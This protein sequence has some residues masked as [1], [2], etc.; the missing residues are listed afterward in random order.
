MF[1]SPNNW[2]H[3]WDKKR[4]KNN[5][6]QRCLL[7]FVL[8]RC[9]C[10]N[11]IKMNVLLSTWLWLSSQWIVSLSSLCCNALI[12][13]AHGPEEQ[14]VVFQ[15]L[16][17]EFIWKQA[18]GAVNGWVTDD[19][20]YGV[21]E[22]GIR[23]YRNCH[24]SSYSHPV[25]NLCWDSSCHTHPAAPAGSFNKFQYQ[26]E[27]KAVSL[28]MQCNNAAKHQNCWCTACLSSVEVTC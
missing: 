20:I 14:E 5:K 27:K 12:K 3:S 6:C 19:A 21:Q 25:E 26:R 1:P 15:G 8:K 7:V 28:V 13:K 17:L 22:E 2:K 4:D 9:H 10:L 24:I 23:S 11:A 16:H 18:K